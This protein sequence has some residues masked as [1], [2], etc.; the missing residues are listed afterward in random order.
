MLAYGVGNVANDFW[1]EQVVK[2]G[3]TDTSLPNVLEPRLTPAWGVLLA[4]AAL[5]WLG[6]ER[7]QQS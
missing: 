4:A 2:R 1:L 5:L 3:W 7:R 6:V